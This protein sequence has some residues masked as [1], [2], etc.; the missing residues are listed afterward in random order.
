MLKE[1]LSNNIV[2]LY[3]E[4]HFFDASRNILLAW[5]NFLKF[6]L[7]YFSIPLLLIFFSLA[8]LPYVLWKND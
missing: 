4:W 1:I 8:S 3:L 5:K 7:N 2:S 6:N